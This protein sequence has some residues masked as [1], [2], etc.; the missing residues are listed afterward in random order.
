MPYVD[1]SIGGYNNP[2]DQVLEEATRLFPK[3]PVTCVVSIGAGLNQ[4]IKLSGSGAASKEHS[5]N[6]IEVLAKMATE[7][8]TTAERIHKRYQNQ[9]K[10]YFRFNV[11]RGLEKFDVYKTENP[12]D[13]MAYTRGYTDT[14]TV[15]KKIDQVVEALIS[16][17]VHGRGYVTCPARDS[18]QGRLT[19]Y[20]GTVVD[21]GPTPRYLNMAGE[22]EDAMCDH[23]KMEQYHGTR[24]YS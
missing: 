10:T 13:V 23:H 4:V 16:R 15:S 9:A 2:T 20:T 8:D 18:A 21:A 14:I 11:D 19:P 3:Q 17:Y 7:S 5:T 1:G 6:L 24:M 12:A 22:A